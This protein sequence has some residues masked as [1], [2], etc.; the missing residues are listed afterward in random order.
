MKKNSFSVKSIRNYEPPNCKFPVF[1]YFT[2]YERDNGS[3]ILP[4]CDVLLDE[5]GFISL[6]SAYE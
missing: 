3:E 2:I 6:P 5:A 1:G 4:D